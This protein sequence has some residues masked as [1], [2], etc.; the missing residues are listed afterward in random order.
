M[1][2]TS[3]INVVET[4]ALPSPAALLAELPKSDAQADFVTRTRR[5]I[6]RLIFTDDKRFLLIV[7]PCSIHD[8]KAG[9]VYAQQLAELAREVSDRV[10]YLRDGRVER[11]VRR[12]DL[13]IVPGGITAG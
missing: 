6:H 1:Q 5:E 3:D 10:I 7:G 11:S 2:K 8:L 12:A 9:R 13:A 4:R